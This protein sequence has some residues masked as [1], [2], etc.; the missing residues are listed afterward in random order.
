MYT[1]DTLG[2]GMTAAGSVLLCTNQANQKHALRGLSLGSGY[3]LRQGGRLSICVTPLWLGAP[4]WCDTGYNRTMLPQ[5][6][7]ASIG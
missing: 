1:R 4:Q 7:P 3:H 2:S 5:A 6:K